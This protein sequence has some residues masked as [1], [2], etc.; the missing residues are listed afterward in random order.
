MREAF[1]GDDVRPK[2]DGWMTTREFCEATKSESGKVMCRAQ[3]S[4]WLNRGERAGLLETAWGQINQHRVK[5]YREKQK[6]SDPVCPQCLTSS[7]VWVNQITGK[8]TC[9]RVGCHIA[10]EKEKNNATNAS[11]VRPVQNPGGKGQTK[12]Q[13]ARE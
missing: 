6:Q 2:G 11:R 7:Q 10:I 9:H 5:F 8:L 12:S 1:S 3:M 13:K 4:E